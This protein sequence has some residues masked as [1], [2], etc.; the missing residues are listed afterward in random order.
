MAEDNQKTVTVVPP[1]NHRGP[2]GM[3]DL[4][5]GGITDEETDTN[6]P[7]E[8]E[9]TFNFS[10]RTTSTGST[11]T[12]DSHMLE[13]TRS[14]DSK[15]E[16]MAR[17]IDKRLRERVPVTFKARKVFLKHCRQIAIDKGYPKVSRVKYS[18]I[19]SWHEEV[20]QEAEDNDAEG[21]LAR[22]I[23]FAGILCHT[24]SLA[25]IL[26]KA[27]EVGAKV[28][29]EDDDEFHYMDFNFFHTM[30]V[31]RWPWCRHGLLGA[32]SV[33]LAFYILTPVLFCVIMQDEGICPQDTKVAGWVSALYFASTT[34]STVGYGDLSVEKDEAWKVFVGMAYMIASLLVALF[35]FSAAA[36]SAVS[37]SFAKRFAKWVASISPLTYPEGPLKN[38]EFLYQRIRKVQFIALGDIA[39]Q[40]FFLNLIGVLSS[41]AFIA[42]AEVDED[43]KW[44]WMES[45]YW[46]VQTTTTIG[47]GDY[48]MPDYMR[49]FQIIYLSLGTYFTGSALGKLSALK[50]EMETIRRYHAF[51]RREVNKHMMHYL[52]STGTGR[53]DQYEFV[54]ASLLNLGKIDAD[55]IDPIMEKFRSLEASSGRTG[56][57]TVN[58]LADTSDTSLNDEIGRAHV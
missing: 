26:D 36:D 45:M 12:R 33:V 20:K 7:M 11:W 29:L 31:S 50:E 52:S 25:E 41:Q 21:I 5:Q 27:K 43:R 2:S 34:M 22:A 58:K 49:W 35:A 10:R 44:N 55:D 8:S 30:L 39:F 32:I 28:G 17:K 19:K 38:D 1:P 48:A 9:T 4:E 3:C 56:Y 47:Y 13:S 54:I 42:Y 24:Q 18:D 53:V 15:V 40:F 51:E 14:G 46:A 57:I 6:S 23:H 16:R 37:N